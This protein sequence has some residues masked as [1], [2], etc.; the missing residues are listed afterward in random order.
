M[1]R[2]TGVDSPK[3]GSEGGLF[4]CHGIPLCA[5]SGKGETNCITTD[6]LTTR[7]RISPKRKQHYHIIEL[8]ISKRQASSA[9]HSTDSSVHLDKQ[10]AGGAQ[11]G[12]QNG[13]SRILIQ[14]GKRVREQCYEYEKRRGKT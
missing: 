14:E 13:K 2:I 9:G 7:P 6:H 3:V 12:L 5:F 10:L 11:N 1:S 8:E 4:Q